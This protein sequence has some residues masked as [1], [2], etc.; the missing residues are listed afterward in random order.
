MKPKR[1]T[2]HDVASRAGVGSATVDRV[3]NERGQVS[4]E[5]SRKVLAAARELGLRRVLPQ[6]H[7]GLIRINVILARPELP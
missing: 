2:L 1:I 7:H 3:I 4:E 6:S 5:V